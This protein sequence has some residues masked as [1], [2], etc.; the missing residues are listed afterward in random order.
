MKTI[1]ISYF[2][3]LKSI[4]RNW[5]LIVALLIPFFCGFILI[6][7]LP[8][9]NYF[10]SCYFQDNETLCSLYP[11]FQLVLLLLPTLMIA[12]ISVTIVLEEIDCGIAKYLCVTPL[13][14]HGYLFTRFIINCILIIPYTIGI[15]LL[16]EIYKFTI[17]KLFSICLL[18]SIV[19][20]VM[21]LM[22]I[23]LSKNKVEG[24]A[25]MKLVCMLFLLGLIIPFV[26]ANDVQ[27]LFFFLP[28]FWIA[29]L[30]ISFDIANFLI[31]SCCS[32]LWYKVLKR[33]FEY[34]KLL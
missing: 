3:F 6:V 30:A 24:M 2:L 27:Y 34:K 20:C 16:F 12:F 19:G 21:A 15:N 10:F 31:A 9:L 32:L 28:T 17:V 26:I 25:F 23:T 5:A 11:L 13:N 4:C 29:K 33:K 14:K 22:I 1:K 8:I 7:F 18:F